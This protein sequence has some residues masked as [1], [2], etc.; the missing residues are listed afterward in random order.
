M[1]TNWEFW[2]AYDTAF[3]KWADEVYI[4]MQDGWKDSIGVTAEIKIAKQLGK[5]IIYIE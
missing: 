5:P 2:K 4:F 3:L 1:P